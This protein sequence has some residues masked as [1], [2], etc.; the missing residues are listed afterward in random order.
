MRPLLPQPP[1]RWPGILFALIAIIAAAFGFVGLSASDF[2]IDELYTLHLV[3]HQSGLAE[4]FKRAL[5]DTHPP[6][7]YFLLYGWTR[8]AGYS[9]TA[10]RLP[11]VVFTLS[12]LIIFAIGMRR[13][14]S[15]NAIAFACAIAA[16]SPFWFEQSQ[17]ARDYALGMAL[18]A[19]MLTSAIAVFRQYRRNDGIQLRQL[20]LLMLIGLAASFTHAYLLLAF[21]MMLLYLL[22]TI[23][24]W[25]MRLLIV[26]A[27]MVILLANTGYYW[28]LTHST[29]QDLQH[30]WFQNSVNFFR[31]QTR[32][33]ISG[34]LPVSIEVIIIGLL[35][36]LWFQRSTGR[37]DSAIAT[38]EPEE[39]RWASRLA[40]LVLIGVIVC[41]IA[42]SLLVAPSYSYRNVLIC[43]PFAWLLLARLYDTAGPRACSRSSCVL[44]AMIVV[45]LGINLAI[46]KGRLLPRNEPWRES[47]DYIREQYPQCLRQP[48]PVVLPFKFGPSS[49]PFRTLA[50]RD[51]FGHYLPEATQLLALLPAELA[52]RHPRAGL[53]ALFVQRATAA[54]TGGCPV[55][56]WGVHD[57]SED[58]ALKI[59]QDLARQP[60][61]AGH[62]VVIQEFKAYSQHLVW[63][64][65]RALG[66]VFLL[67]PPAEASVH[68]IAP[69]FGQ[70][71]IKAGDRL[72]VDHLA[73][74]Q[75]NSG[76]PYLVDVYSIQRWPANRTTASEDFIASRRLTCDPPTEIARKDVWPDPAY[77]G[78][79]QG[80]LPS[81]ALLRNP[82]D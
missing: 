3:N 4:V 1:A 74:K 23:A 70:A 62:R 66:F 58:G 39:I 31:N 26:A 9:E 45:F 56:A 37:R 51:F 49:A 15:R 8:L 47:A 54:D 55:L 72:V 21:G 43:V 30:M 41:G 27:G 64:N 76:P 80:L 53:S 59:A 2:S 82:P 18:S 71:S 29:Q 63:W 36:S 14:A 68:S 6:L 34:L 38:V 79:S 17:N 48:L 69:P 11:S 13:I 78:C 10:M 16:L 46:L 50:E 25:R 35:L 20:S 7:Y 28:L 61:L 81:Q 73:T 44:A 75:S 33:A 5:T 52:M 42:V 65:Q 40:G 19:A 77:P 12:A 32:T 22:L 57:L 67:A 60:A 24:N